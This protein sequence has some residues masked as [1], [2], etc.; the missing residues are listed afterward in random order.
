MKLAWLRLAFFG[1]LVLVMALG[2]LPLAWAADGGY[3]RD[4]RRSER[5]SEMRGSRTDNRMGLRGNRGGGG[6]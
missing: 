3:R 2:E 4:E 6:G 5:R 1:W